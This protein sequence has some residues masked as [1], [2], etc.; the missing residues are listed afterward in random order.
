MWG[1]KEA[2]MPDDVFWVRI[3]SWHIVRTFTR[4]QG[5][6]ITACGRS[7]R[8]ADFVDQRPANERSCESCYRIAGPE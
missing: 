6:A 8:G 4:V 2:P 3:R 7:V 5:G 1:T